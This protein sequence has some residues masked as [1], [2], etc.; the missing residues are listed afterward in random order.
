VAREHNRAIVLPY[1]PK[2][3][4]EGR[5]W[6]DFGQV[7]KK[8]RCAIPPSICHDR[9]R[10]GISKTK[11]EPGHSRANSVEGRVDSTLK[12]VSRIRLEVS[13]PDGQIHNVCPVG[14]GLP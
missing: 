12:Q 7:A 5:A 1:H 9:P 10:D 13:N 8:M 3:D 6:R 4:V 2:V 11:S 14:P